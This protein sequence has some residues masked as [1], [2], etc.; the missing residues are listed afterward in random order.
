MIN[1]LQELKLPKTLNLLTNDT[2]K[3]IEY[4]D[5]L[6]KNKSVD[7]NKIFQIIENKL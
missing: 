3:F 6:L 2:D 4:Y 7:E 1:K 5:Y